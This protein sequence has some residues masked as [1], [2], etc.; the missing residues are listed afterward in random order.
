MARKVIGSL[1]I[2]PFATRKCGKRDNCNMNDFMNLTVFQ[3]N[4]INYIV[5]W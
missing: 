4:E 2:R 3:E 5:V 1:E